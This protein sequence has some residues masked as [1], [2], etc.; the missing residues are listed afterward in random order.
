MFGYGSHSRLQSLMP[1][2]NSLQELYEKQK[3]FNLCNISSNNRLIDGSYSNCSVG[4]G[5]GMA[6]LTRL[7]LEE[8]L[9]ILEAKFVD[10]G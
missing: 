4:K 9:D 8:A 7:S 10:N 1:V 6:V 3:A 2:T 5:R